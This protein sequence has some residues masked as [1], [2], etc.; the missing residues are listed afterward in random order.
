MTAPISFDSTTSRYQLPLLVAGQS[1]KEFTV[2][3]AL[4]RLDAMI[5]TVVEGIAS[6]PP[7]APVAGQSWIVDTSPG[8]EWTG[9]AYKIASWNGNRWTFISPTIGTR[10]FGIDIGTYWHF[11]SG[12]QHALPISDPDAGTTIDTEARSAIVA[13]LQALRAI[14]IIPET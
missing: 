8:G 6:A 7:T 11:D 1:Q 10:A 5:G 3:E 12:W 9:N 14:S 2:N 4:T 13:I